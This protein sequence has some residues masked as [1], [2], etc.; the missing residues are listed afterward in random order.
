MKRISLFLSI[1]VITISSFGQNYNTNKFRQLK[2]ELP[3]PN[4]YRTAAGAPGHGYYQQKADY[5]LNIRLDDENQ[6]LFGE[7]TVTYYNNSPDQLEY[8]WVQLDQN[9]RA[10]DSDTKKISGGT[11]SGN[12]GSWYMNRLLNQFDGGFKIDYLKKSNGKAQSFTINKTMLRINLDKP[13]APGKSFSFKM[14]WNYNINDRDKVGGRSG[15][16]YF[17]EEDNYL[18]TIAQF[19]PRMCVYND[20]EGWQ[21]KQ[22]LG[23]GEFALVFGDYKNASLDESYFGALVQYPNAEGSVED[24]TTFSNSLKENNAYLVVVEGWTHYGLSAR[25]NS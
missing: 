15:M 25:V 5:D 14:K 13:L 6:K 17:K 7:G 21:N 2:Q 9:V 23:R 16:E 18:Y 24:Y 8:L 20:V 22:F 1:L 4:I 10:K 11:V 12:V 19:Y 3:T